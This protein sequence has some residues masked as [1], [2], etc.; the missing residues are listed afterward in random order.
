MLEQFA[1][2]ADSD[3]YVLAEA[4]RI[5]IC[6][7][8]PRRERSPSE[9]SDLTRQLSKYASDRRGGLHTLLHRLAECSSW[10]ILSL[11]GTA[12]LAAVVLVLLLAFGKYV[13]DPSS[14]PMDPSFWQSFRY[15]WLPRNWMKVPVWIILGLCAPVVGWVLNKIIP[16]DPEPNDH[17]VPPTKEALIRL[18]SKAAARQ[19]ALILI[20]DR[21]WAL[22]PVDEVVLGH[23]VREA[24][25]R[26]PLFKVIPRLMLITVDPL[27]GSRIAPGRADFATL[28]LAPFSEVELRQILEA[29]WPTAS[30][31]ELAQLLSQARIDITSVLGG[32]EGAIESQ[33]ESAFRLE[34]ENSIGVVLDLFK[35]II[36]WA[37]R[38]P[39]SVMKDELY[40]W[41]REFNPEFLRLFGLK[42]PESI[43][44]LVHG[45][46]KSFLV[47]QGHDRLFL[48]REATRL[49]RDTI[50]A[51]SPDLLI[52]AHCFWGLSLGH[53]LVTPGA[54]SPNDIEQRSRVRE[55]AWHLALLGERLKE[56]TDVF[57]RFPGKPK[58]KG[59][60]C[61]EAA[62]CL[63]TAAAINRE[64]GDFHQAGQFVKQALKWIGS[65][66]QRSEE[67]ILAAT[68]DSVWSLYWYN[69]GPEASQSI[70]EVARDFPDARKTVAWQTHEICRQAFS[71]QKGTEETGEEP[72]PTDPDLQN[73]REL[74]RIM[75]SGREKS[76]FL[77]D[78]LREG[79]VSASEPAPATRHRWAE[80][81][82]RYV[83]VKTALLRG[84]PGGAINEMRA[85]VARIND[86]S[87]DRLGVA[88]EALSDF[89]SGQCAQMLLWIAAE[90]GNVNKVGELVRGGPWKETYADSEAIPEFLLRQAKAG[91]VSATRDASLLAMKPLLAES[92]FE[93]AELLKRYS[94]DSSHGDEEW[95]SW[96]TAFDTALRTDVEL[97]WKFRAPVIHHA[98]WEYFGRLNQPTAV[99][100]A[101]NTYRS[102]KA[103]CFPTRIILEWHNRL[104]SILINYADSL[105]DQERSAELNESW[106]RDLA[107]LPEANEQ[108][109]FKI[110]LALEQANS[111]QFAAQAQRLRRDFAKAESLLSEAE[112]SYE[113]GVSHKR[114][115]EED[116]GEIREVRLAL[117]LQRV[118]LA[119][120]QHHEDEA[121]NQ[122]LVIWNELKSDD[123]MVSNVLRSVVQVEQEH[124]MLDD[125]WP[126]T[127]ETEATFEPLVGPIPLPSDWQPVAATV[128]RNRFEFRMH[129]LVCLISNNIRPSLAELTLAARSRFRRYEKFAEAC[130]YMGELEV[131]GGYSSKANREVLVDMLQATAEYFERVDPERERKLSTLKALIKLRPDMKELHLEYA[132]S[133]VM[134]GSLLKR[135]LRVQAMVQQPDW[136]SMASRIDHLLSVLAEESMQA[137]QIAR[138]LRQAHVSQGDFHSWLQQQQRN[139]VSA[140]DYFSRGQYEQVLGIW[141]GMEKAAQEGAQTTNVLDKRKGEGW[142]FLTD[143][144]LLDLFLR[145]G[146]LSGSAS[147]GE[148]IAWQTRL[149]DSA[150]HFVRQFGA[151][152]K[153]LEV[154]TLVSE[155]L[156]LLRDASPAW[157]QPV[158]AAAVAT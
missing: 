139:L 140:R 8:D 22:S 108:R 148:L 141:K 14:N 85:V 151:T 7:R 74:T 130:L 24:E 117:K 80:F 35:V 98:R 114:A 33:F 25:E 113:K 65:V 48:D 34:E 61:T 67:A 16:K 101:F 82:I 47:Q 131:L 60:M 10:R 95:K 5:E 86:G 109:R 4:R 94:P 62:L 115:S 75:S 73:I 107:H 66:D 128:V 120:A 29:R 78:A 44:A 84:E 127:T 56:P 124:R 158:A 152:I 89:E 122:L 144:E 157:Q 6:G 72:I 81:A 9:A 142:V 54:N 90:D 156:A 97:G 3:T 27:S 59:K 49:V 28:D 15:E 91:Y 68:A 118:W 112:Q 102:M 83:R 1:M 147:T 104:T 46:R 126:P 42:K 77:A 23:L 146:L 79:V 123:P 103:A 99:T 119:E 39:T 41:L 133:V 153:D 110:V 111:L 92:T 64:E 52:Q 70:D 40:L 19:R 17:A 55:G 71:C 116:A 2:R 88:Q 26:G 13:D 96:E 11:I 135:E 134:F 12:L 20:V 154:Q 137:E 129:Q 37:V 149:R 63:L 21:A 121:E 58:S 150:L 51:N 143:L 105:E 69:G 106:A 53:G 100:D 50:E 125:K 132:R 57:A 30:P 43:D 145:S 18:L 31:P 155:L 32:P 76:G 36:L 93:L 138:Y 136:Y 45:F 38:N 87:K